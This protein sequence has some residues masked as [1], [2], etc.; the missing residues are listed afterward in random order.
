MEKYVMQVHPPANGV[1]VIDLA[2]AFGSD[3]AAQ[4]AVAEHVDAACREWGFLII[5]G[6]GKSHSLRAA[7]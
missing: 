1:P 5:A 2:P 3:R 7:A 6:H 4:Q